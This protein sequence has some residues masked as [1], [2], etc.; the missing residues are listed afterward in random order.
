M[1]DSSRQFRFAAALLGF[2]I[3]VGVVACTGAISDHQSSTG[4]GGGTGVVGPVVL[5][6]RR[7]R[8]ALHAGAHRH[9][10]R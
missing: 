5:G 10:P 7:A 4:T 9:E 1:S 3:P 6:G 8:R 2:A